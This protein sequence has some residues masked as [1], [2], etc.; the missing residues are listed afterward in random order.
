M[1]RGPLD[2]WNAWATQILVLLSLTLQILLLMFAGIRRRKSFTVLRFI[3]W[4]AYQLADSTAIYAVGHL[5]LSSAPREHKLVAFWAPFL[6]LHL[7]GPDNITAYSLEDNKLWKRHLVTLVVQVLGAEY[8]LYKNIPRSGGFL[9]LAA[10]LMFIVGTAKYGERT[11]ALYSANFSSIRGALKKLPRSQLRGYQGYLREEDGHIDAGSDEFLLQ[12]AHSL[13][14][15]CERGIVDSVINEDEIEIK[16]ETETETKTIIKGLMDNP[17]RMWRVMEMELS[18]MYDV[19][20]TK[21]RVI[22]TMIGYCVRAASPLSV[23][24]CFLLFHFTGKHGHSGI[25]VIITYILLGGALFIETTSTLNAVGSSWALSYL[26]TTQWSWLR[27]EALCA[28]RWHRLR[29]AVVTIRQHV[30]T[31]TG[32]S[33]SYY[34]RSRVWSGTIG[35]YNMFYF[36]TNMEIDKADKGLKSFATKL[37]F[38]EW[39]ENTYYSWTVKVPEEV[40]QRALNMVSSKDLNTMGMVRHRW[41]EIVFKHSYPELY[42]ML[43]G[44]DDYYHGIDFHESII[45]CHIA[46]ELLLF[47]ISTSDDDERPDLIRALSNYLMYL[48]VTHP[49]MLPGLPQNWLYEMTCKNLDDLCEGQLGPSRRSDIGTVLKKLFGWND[50]TRPYN[51]D[52]TNKLADIIFQLESRSHQPSVPRLKYGRTIARILVDKSDKNTDPL[53]VLLDLWMDFLIYAA[54]RCNRESHARKLN[55]SGE[56]ITV[57]WLMIE[58]I[59]QTKSK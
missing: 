29:R 24:A 49:D 6:L 21:A 36:C 44:N 28:G 2:L 19:L 18:L 16:T 52:Q 35:Q 56:F 11:W 1:A 23:V 32:G 30:K 9:I 41:G 12:R 20:Y 46:T 53:N 51:L 50:G 17:K 5:S 25:D 33:S 13:F 47:K 38:G 8:V 40:K 27:H 39:W 42:D 55:T 43:V 26:C 22:H 15:I 14:H 7:G 4:L 37:G 34:G 31:M 45:S 57:V 48:L 58:H 3:L 59:Y 10:I 54:N